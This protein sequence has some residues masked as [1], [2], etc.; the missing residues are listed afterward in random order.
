MAEKTKASLE[1]ISAWARM[2]R[3]VAKWIGVEIKK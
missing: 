1:G 3:G 2:E